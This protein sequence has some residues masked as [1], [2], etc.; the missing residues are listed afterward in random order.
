MTVMLVVCAAPSNQ[1]Y[2]TRQDG[3]PLE[4]YSGMS[5]AQLQLLHH[6]SQQ[7]QHYHQQSGQHQMMQH[8]H[9]QHQQQHYHQQSGQH[10]MMQHQ[11]QDEQERETQAIRDR[12][13]RVKLEAQ[14]GKT[15]MVESNDAESLLDGA[16]A[17]FALMGQQMSASASSTSA[18][19]G[20]S[21]TDIRVML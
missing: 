19:S 14:V 12:Q 17:L 6:H 15:P 4:E 3:T 5:A 7:Q 10:Q 1:Q 18:A 9:Q 8:Q 2:D 13:P 21:T 11:Q 16:D 20:L